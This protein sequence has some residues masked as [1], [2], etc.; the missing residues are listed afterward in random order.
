MPQKTLDKVIQPDWLLTFT[1]L[2]HVTIRNSS[3]VSSDLGLRYNIENQINCK[4][5]V[6]PRLREG[7]PS[8]TDFR[9]SLEAQQ[10]GSQVQASRV[11]AKDTHTCDGIVP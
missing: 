4:D 8:V 5:P 7:Q 9:K 2:P 6:G 3:K 1:Q 10:V 11:S